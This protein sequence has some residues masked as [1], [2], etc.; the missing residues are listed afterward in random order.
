MWKRKI[1][2]QGEV[3]TKTC[4]F[5]SLKYVSTDKKSPKFLIILLYIQSN[6]KYSFSDF[7]IWKLTVYSN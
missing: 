2:K 4:S 3:V 6:R 1:D 5:R 7:L